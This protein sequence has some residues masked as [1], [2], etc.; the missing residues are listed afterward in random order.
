MLLTPAVSNA[1]R[2][3][4]HK[5][6]ST[7]TVHVYKSGL[8]SGL[9][10]N[11]VIQAPIASGS[12]DTKEQAVEITFNVADM[13]VLDPD[14]STSERQE[15]EATM[16]G[17]KVLESAQFPVINFVSTGI[18]SSSPGHSQV[19]GTFKLHGFSRQVSV[20]VV[21]RDGKY[22]GSIMLKQT[23]YGITP[24]KIAGGAVRVKDEIEIEF[25]VVPE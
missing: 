18:S 13:K 20:S 23:D 9:A 7:V 2:I 6:H 10:H 1:Q 15:I 11:H 5:A 4:I 19:T 3:A 14:A 17:P 12:L 24:V 22:S 16:K 21:L 25:Q 8:L